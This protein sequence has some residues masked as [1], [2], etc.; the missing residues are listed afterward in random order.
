MK[1]E[2][3]H[4]KKQMKINRANYRMTT[5]EILDKEKAIKEKIDELLHVRKEPREN[6]YLIDIA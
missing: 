2:L 4:N 1:K 5:K 6:F 3:P